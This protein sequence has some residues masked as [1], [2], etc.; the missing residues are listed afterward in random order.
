MASRWQSHPLQRTNCP[1]FDCCIGFARR[2]HSVICAECARR[3]KLCMGSSP[4][5]GMNESHNES[6]GPSACADG[7]DRADRPFFPICNVNVRG[8]NVNR[9]SCFIFCK[10][11]ITVSPEHLSTLRMQCSKTRATPRDPKA[12]GGETLGDPGLAA[13]AVRVRWTG[14]SALLSKDAAPALAGCVARPCVILQSCVA[15]VPRGEP[16]TMV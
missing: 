14:S 7:V 6:P 1:L 12:R 2:A 10:I 5:H 9:P 15:S 13:V 3:A 16:R 11:F 8:R 4:M